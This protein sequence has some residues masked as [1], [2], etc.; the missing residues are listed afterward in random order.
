VNQPAPASRCSQHGRLSPPAGHSGPRGPPTGRR[1]PSRQRR[2]WPGRGVIRPPAGR[3]VLPGH[4]RAG[5]HERPADHS[6]TTAPSRWTPFDAP[7]RARRDRPPFLPRVT[8]TADS[9]PELFATLHV[10]HLA[11]P[12]T[13]LLLPPTDFSA[14]RISPR[15]PPTA[16]VQRADPPGRQRSTRRHRPGPAGSAEGDRRSFRCPG[17]TTSVVPGSLTGGVLA[18]RAP[19]AGHR[20]PVRRTLERPVRSLVRRRTERRCADDV[21]S[22]G[23]TRKTPAARRASIPGTDQHELGP[24]R[25]VGARLGASAEPFQRRGSS[26]QTYLYPLVTYQPCRVESSAMR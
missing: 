25:Q 26:A 9:V 19:S 5:R 23:T 10:H 20:F 7:P 18:G 3:G 17:G 13:V 1:G 2:D 12:P 14:V 8:V 6:A 24:P 22:A 4:L 21:G 16:V 15:P 11:L